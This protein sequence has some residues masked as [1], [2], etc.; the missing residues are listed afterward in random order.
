MYYQKIEY[1]D[2]FQT[3]RWVKRDPLNGTLYARLD[4]NQEAVDKEGGYYSMEM[5]DGIT[6]VC[7]TI[8]P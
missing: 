7:T 6:Q 4:F 1:R 3:V 8:A 5:L 2:T